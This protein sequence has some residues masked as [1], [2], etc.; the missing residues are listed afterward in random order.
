MMIILSY[1]RFENCV[2]GCKP[3]FK[4][5]LGLC[6]C[7]NTKYESRARSKQH[8]LYIITSREILMHGR[9]W[10]AG[11]NLTVYVSVWMM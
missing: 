6:T 3:G 9:C 2:G 7:A 8:S 1:S 5:V 11:C 10:E 4:C